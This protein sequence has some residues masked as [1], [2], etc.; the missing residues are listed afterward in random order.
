MRPPLL[1]WIDGLYN[2]TAD[3]TIITGSDEKGYEEREVTDGC[4]R[5]HPESNMIRWDMTSIGPY[6]L[7]M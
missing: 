6:K 7:S 5:Y 1:W 2:A 3:A 4:S